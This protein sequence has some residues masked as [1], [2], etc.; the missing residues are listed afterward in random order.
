N[1]GE[2]RF[3]Q[4]MG[5]IL[6]AGYVI[7]VDYGA[8]WDT[9]SPLD[10]DHFRSYGPGSVQEHSDP[11]HWPTLNDMTSDV[12]FSHIAAEGKSSGLRPLYFGAQSSL[13]LGTGVSMD[14]TPANRDP[15]DFDLWVQNFY[16]WNVYKILVE[17]KEKTD[18]AY[19]FPG[20]EPEPLTV[21]IAN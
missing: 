3:I 21:D 19:S 9:V 17:Q 2:G 14:E 1:L 6:K 15:G 11:Y 18:A 5:R 8:N 10:F 7:T 20:V 16:L 12:N 4:G 13:L